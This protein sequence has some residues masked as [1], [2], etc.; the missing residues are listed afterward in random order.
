LRTR[1][2]LK[3]PGR[4]QLGLRPGMTAP[5]RRSK[6]GPRAPGL[7]TGSSPGASN[8][9][10]TASDWAQ[11]PSRP[12]RS[13]RGAP[14]GGQSGSD[15]RCLPGPISVHRAAQSR[16]PGLQKGEANPLQDIYSRLE[17]KSFAA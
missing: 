14:L 6:S 17:W 1:P 12:V 11:P 9:K 2:A 16:F 13:P 8:L 5:A 10:G 15:R 3:A 4:P 7:T